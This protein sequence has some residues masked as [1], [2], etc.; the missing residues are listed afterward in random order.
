LVGDGGG[1]KFGGITRCWED[2][3]R[4]ANIDIW[5]ELLEEASTALRIVILVLSR[6]TIVI[7]K[8]FPTL[9]QAI[10]SNNMRAFEPSKQP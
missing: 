8:R 5:S 3:V 2:A 9:L 7:D 1:G 4:V 10:V 6:T